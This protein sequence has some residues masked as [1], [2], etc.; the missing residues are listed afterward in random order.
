M[1][2]LHG[3]EGGGDVNPWLGHDRYL[4]CNGEDLRELNGSEGTRSGAAARVRRYLPFV[5]A[6]SSHCHTRTMSDMRLFRLEVP[7]GGALRSGRGRHR[8]GRRHVARGAAPSPG[9]EYEKWI[10]RAQMMMH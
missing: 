6:R 8:T 4:R 1:T 7:L 9:A 10:T 2:Q 3:T 5:E